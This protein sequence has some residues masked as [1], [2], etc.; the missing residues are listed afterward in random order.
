MEGI[1]LEENVRDISNSGIEI[2]GLTCSIQEKNGA[3]E[4]I[5][6]TKD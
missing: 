1:F 3:K 4:V 2:N 5:N 6:A